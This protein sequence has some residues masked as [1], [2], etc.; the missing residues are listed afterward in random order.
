MLEDLAERCV[1]AGGRAYALP[2]DV[3]DAK[4]VQRAAD[5]LRTECG[6]IDVMIANAGVSGADV[7]TRRYDPAGVKKVID[8]NLLGAVNAVRAVLPQ[9]LERGSGQLV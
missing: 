8:I 3:V 7:E 1:A 4:A 5:E 2:C 6:H 9:M